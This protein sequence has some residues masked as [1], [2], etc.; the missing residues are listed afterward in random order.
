MWI[1]HPEAY[2]IGVEK[3]LSQTAVYN[4]L[5][6]WK[7]RKVELSGIKVIKRTIPIRAI[8]PEGKDKVARLQMHEPA[9]ERGEIHLRPEMKTLR[10]QILFLGTNT[11]EFDDRADSLI[12]ALDLSYASTKG[13]VSDGDSIYNQRA[14]QTIAGNIEKEIF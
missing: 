8:S 9:F 1:R 5:L 11:I 10:D 7:N 13:I 12:F 14:K 3:I 2:V 4:I 6:D